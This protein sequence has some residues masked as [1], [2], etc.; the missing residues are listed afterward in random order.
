M[1]K[2]STLTPDQITLA[3]PRDRGYTK[4]G[5]PWPVRMAVGAAPQADR[6]QT[7]RNFYPDAVPW[8]EDNFVYTDPED[9]QVTLYNP[10]G[11]DWGDIPAGIPEAAAMVGG[12]IGA[13]AG[14]A[15]GPPGAIL[16]GGAGAT[17]GQELAEAAVRSFIPESVDTRSY[18]EKTSD[19][20]NSVLL[21]SAGE[22]V[23]RAVGDT[24]VDAARGALIAPGSAG[25]LREAQDL[26]I[27]TAGLSAEIGGRP[28]TRMAAAGLETVPSATN[29]MNEARQRTVDSM[30]DRLLGVSG[31]RSK[32]EG[33]LA[34][35]EGQEQASAGF[36]E[37]E[38]ELRA[39][40]SEAAGDLPIVPTTMPETVALQQQWARALQDNPSAAAHLQPA[41]DEA[42]SL[43]DDA[44]NG[45]VP[46]DLL[47]ERMTH[48]TQSLQNPAAGTG[49]V[50]KS[51]Q[52]LAKL[53]KALRADARGSVAEGRP[54]AFPIAQEYDEYVSS[55]LT[56]GGSGKSEAQVIEQMGKRETD[57]LMSFALGGSKGGGQ[58]LE[59]MRSV[60]P[61]E[62]WETFSQAVLQQMGSRGGGAD[63]FSIAQFTTRW[64]QMDPAARRAV[65]GKEHDFLDRLA[66]MG[67]QMKISDMEKNASKTAQNLNLA[68]TLQTVGGGAGGLA[69][70]GGDPLIAAAVGAGA[71][72]LPW[73]AAKGL[74]SEGFGQ[75]AAGGGVP[76][77]SGL[78]GTAGRGMAL[79]PEAQA[80]M[81]LESI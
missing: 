36:W 16:G 55:Y 10:S 6:L 2:K 30:A 44:S 69:A 24:L 73:A 18:L 17:A 78:G 81:R 40:L 19:Q 38:R 43:L 42:T 52:A 20:A 61:A 3:S 5:S 56:P 37:R 68:R 25:R 72:A 70:G 15:A 7:M 8:G 53:E 49:Y 67:E 4:T 60:M 47:R 27:D 21:N 63:E 11:P 45:G 74:T 28:L 64:R 13:L 75:F 46:Y 35:R 34:L 14:G 79:T 66:T 26:G 51:G 71:T 65:F 41:L 57:Q 39:Q 22:G 1:A 62:Q 59:Q 80:L 48:I 29:T 50:G 9:G 76:L 31:R 32:G 12:G 54:D 33:A 23:G 58:R 77:I